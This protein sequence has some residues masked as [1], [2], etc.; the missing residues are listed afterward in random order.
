MSK[1]ISSICDFGILQF[2]ASVATLRIQL[3]GE[4]SGL[5]ACA[6]EPFGDALILLPNDSYSGR[7]KAPLGMFVK[8]GTDDDLNYE[9]VTQK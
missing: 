2:D 5:H 1:S 3:I 6:H 4:P 7:V 9:I 8:E